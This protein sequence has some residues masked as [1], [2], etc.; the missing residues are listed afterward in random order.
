M[1]IKKI[2]NEINIFLPEGAEESLCGCGGVKG[3]KALL[4]K[5]SDIEALGVIHHALADKKRIKILCMLSIQ[6]LCVCIIR[7]VL[8]ISDSRLS[9]HLSI[10]K[11]S[12]LISGEQKGTWITYS[13]TDKG[14]EWLDSGINSV[15]VK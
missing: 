13:L 6:P 9:Y 7:A 5:D 15:F 12:G 8:E 2:K 10:L 3:L 11:K 4:P 1:G 14:K